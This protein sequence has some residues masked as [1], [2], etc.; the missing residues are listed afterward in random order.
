M[1]A[2]QDI[3]RKVAAGE[4]WQWVRSGFMLY[5]KNPLLLS[6]AFAMLFGVV[7]AL[8]LVPQVGGALSEFASPLMVAGFM[9][10]F[11][12]LDEGRDLEL[13]H[14]LAGVRGP[15][16]PLMTIGAVQI[17]GALAIG[18]V[19]EKMGFDAEAFVAAARTQQD[20]VVLQAMLNEAA[21]AVLAGLLLF[22]PLM[23]AT[24]FAP[25]LILFGGA[26]PATALGVSM[27]AVLRN[28]AAL[29]VNGLA[30]GGMLFLA[31]LVPLMLGLLVAMPVLFGSLYASYQAIFAVW[32]DETKPPQ[33]GDKFA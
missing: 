30:I 3:P 18:L 20:P 1:P 23:M 26:R 15:A 22:T 32:S 4:G 6:A 29:L 25:A 31:A 16:I 21:P 14:F 10:A 11:R 27:K 17:M 7:M 9:A 19:M 8:G 13:P 2:P 28:W 33:A 24:W 5:R 12:A